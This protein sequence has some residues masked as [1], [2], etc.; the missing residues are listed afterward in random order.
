[1]LACGKKNLHFSGPER[2]PVDE[3]KMTRTRGIY[4]WAREKLLMVK[5]YFPAIT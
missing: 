1:M 4:G 5:F 3:A 2:H